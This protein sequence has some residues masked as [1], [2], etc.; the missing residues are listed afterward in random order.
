M[1][2]GESV[3]GM[4]IAFTA[5]WGGMPSARSLSAWRIRLTNRPSARI[6]LPMAT[7]F[8]YLRLS[9]ASQIASSTPEASSTITI[10]SFACWPLARSTL[11]VL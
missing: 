6:G 11:V 7:S 5:L 3:E 1:A 9:I 8:V 2:W 10:R 4:R